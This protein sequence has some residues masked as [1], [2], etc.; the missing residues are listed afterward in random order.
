MKGFIYI[1]SFDFPYKRLLLASA[2]NIREIFNIDVRISESS[3]KTL[4]NA[5]NHHRR[6][7]HAGTVLRILD[8]YRFPSMKKLIGIMDKDLYEEG[9][10]FV[11]GEAI[12][13]GTCAILS[14][15]RLYSEREELFIER[16]Q[17][18]INHELGHT[19]GLSHCSN[20]GCVMNFSNSV[21][22]VDKKSKYFCVRCLKKI[23]KAVI[24]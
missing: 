8:T 23:E 6:Q 5:Y 4:A 10:N 14:T 13:G 17:K 3:L 19:F 24:S 22:E 15:Y 18:E 1:I 11:F 21:Y 7:Y 16:I 2:L 12:K 20:E 9:L